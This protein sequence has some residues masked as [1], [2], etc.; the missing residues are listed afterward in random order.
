MDFQNVF[1][2]AKD[3]TI[4]DKKLGKG[5]FGTVYVA[6]LKKDHLQCAAKVIN[7]LKQL[8]LAK[9]QN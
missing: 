1:F 9:I 4:T 6:E 3:F 8:Y 5:V 7:I 2:N